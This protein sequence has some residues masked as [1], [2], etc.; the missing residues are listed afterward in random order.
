MLWEGEART[1]SSGG[2]DGV[3]KK[4][5]ARVKIAHNASD[6]R[7]GMEAYSNLH[8]PGVRVVQVDRDRVGGAHGFQRKA[9][10]SHGMIV[11]CLRQTPDTHVR[12]ANCFH[13]EEAKLAREGVKLLVQAVQHRHHFGWLQCGGDVGVADDVAEENRHRFEVLWL[14][15]A[16][17]LQCFSDVGWE[18]LVEQVPTLLQLVRSGQGLT[19]CRRIH[20]LKVESDL[21]EV[22]TL[23][24]VLGPTL[25]NNLP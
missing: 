4:T 17:F 16:A 9:S 13:L 7:A 22:G 12:V 23:S 11:L 25:G 3:A 15:L 20:A 24:G 8:K 19:G 18:H 14:H 21:I 1:H 10:H 5:V 6:H 2:V